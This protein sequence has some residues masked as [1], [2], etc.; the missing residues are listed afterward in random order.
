MQTLIVV[1]SILL[2]ILSV[3]VISF[4]VFLIYVLLLV[5]K[6]LVKIQK[7]VDNVERS[8]LRSFIPLVSLRTMFSDLEGFVSSIKA[9]GRILTGKKRVDVDATL[10]EKNKG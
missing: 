7:T 1:S 5:R 8:A 2:I 9:W 4:L 6:T 3:V 10:K